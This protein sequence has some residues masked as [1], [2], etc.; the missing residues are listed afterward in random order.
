MLSLLGTAVILYL[1]ESHSIVDISRS[2]IV[3]RALIHLKSN[4]FIGNIPPQICQL[5][6]LKDFPFPHFKKLVNRIL[7]NISMML[8]VFTKVNI[9][10][11]KQ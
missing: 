8:K 5:S 1:I 4:R 6:S 11:Q 10:K 3:D 7:L 9:M 2:G